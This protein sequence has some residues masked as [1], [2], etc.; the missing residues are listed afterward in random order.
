MPNAPVNF[1]DLP[2][3][4]RDPATARYAVLPVPF[5]GTVT[6]KTGTAGGAAA[7]LEASAQVEWFDEQLRREF[8]QA[9]IATC[10]FVLP[11]PGSQEQLERVKKAARPILRAGKFLLTIG[12]EHSITIALAEA[13]AEVHGEISVLQIDAHAD[14]RDSYNGDRFSHACVMRRVLETTDRICQVGIRNFSQEEFDACGKQ[15]ANFITPDEIASN[16]NWIGKALKLLGEKVYITIDIDGLD[17]S[18]APGVGTPEPGGLTWQQVTALLRRVCSERQV[19]A[20]DIVEVRP[21][22]PNHITEFL[23]ARLAYKI[24][25]YTQL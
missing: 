20:A 4:Y 7:I 3:E 12:G 6:Y 25:A 18:I 1:M 8:V 5:E 23:A 16:R 24:I 13:T 10:P 19:V 15:V 22:P 9:G 11:A 2:P 14:L 17:P 21:I